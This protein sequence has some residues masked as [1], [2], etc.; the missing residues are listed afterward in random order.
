MVT[1]AACGRTMRGQRADLVGVVHADLEH[2]ALGVA[3][4]PRQRQRH[5]DVVVVGLHRRMRRGRRA[6]GPAMIAWVTL[7]LPT[8][9]VTAPR[10]ACGARSR[11]ATPSC[12]SAAQGVA[13]HHRRAERPG[14]R[15][16][17]R[18]RPSPR[19]GSTN[20]WPSRTPARATNR[21]P[22]SSVRVSMETPVAR[23]G[24]R[25]PACRRWPRRS[26]RRSRAAQPCARLQ[27]RARVSATSSKGWTTS[28]TIW[29]CSWPLPAT[30]RMSPSRSIADGR[31]GSPR[32][33]R[34]S[35]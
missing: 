11:A 24:P 16:A 21:S 3:R 2:R 1:T 27:A 18:P 4:H 20:S 23:E 35:P 30:T 7:V 25:R 17:R 12:S 9:P 26:R 6:S 13:D 29:P 5:A 19:P 14:A 22:G 10:R 34:R 33:G 15:P 32:G 8:E 28:P 31:R